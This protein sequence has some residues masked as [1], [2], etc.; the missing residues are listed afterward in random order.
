MRASWLLTL[1]GCLGGAAAAAADC[2]N[3]LPVNGVET[4]AGCDPAKADCVSAANA[5]LANLEH[6][7]EDPAVVTVALQAS[8]WRAYDGDFRV[9][10]PEELAAMIQPVLAKKKAGR[11]QLVASWTG[12]KPGAKQPSVAERVAHLLKGVRVTGADGF[13]WVRPDGSLRTTQQSTSVLSGGGAFVVKGAE[14]MASATVAWPMGQLEKARAEKDARLLLLAGAAW[15]IFGLC[16]QTALEL[17]EEAADLG[18]STAA[19]NAALMR[20]ELGGKGDRE[21]A[22]A[23][24]TQAAKAGLAPA[25]ARLEKL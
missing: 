21:K 9:L 19:W 11:V 1:I 8:P 3:A 12:V 14:V 16:P 7:A 5:L 2:K 22:K 6:L 25:R 24:L 15:D 20:L 10:P 17:F 4:I 18:S 13:L 23:L